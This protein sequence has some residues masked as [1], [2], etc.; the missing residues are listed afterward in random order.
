M[1]GNNFGVVLRQVMVQ[2]H[3]KPRLLSKQSGIPEGTLK[4]WLKGDVRKPQQWQDVILLAKTMQLDEQEVNLLLSA[5][6]KE[7]VAQLL[8]DAESDEDLALLEPWA[9]AVQQSYAQAPFQVIAAL[10][11][12]IGRS[13]ILH[14]LE[15][16]LKARRHTHVY[17][18]EGPSGVGKTVLAAH[19][20]YHLRPQFPDGVLWG[21]LI[22]PILY[23]Y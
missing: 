18:I 6:G 20:A 5:A 14:E 21:D 16:E 12:F 13:R 22:P 19:L 17:I 2:R 1:L 3:F 4:H 7:P 10:P 15:E 8:T 11:Y 9:A 23:Q